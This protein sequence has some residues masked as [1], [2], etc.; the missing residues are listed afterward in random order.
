MD[1]S[2]IHVARQD[3]AAAIIHLLPER[4]PVNLF[5]WGKMIFVGTHRAVGDI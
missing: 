5:R 3:L 2:T 1:I 4:L